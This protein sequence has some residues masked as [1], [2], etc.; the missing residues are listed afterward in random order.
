[1][2]R[3]RVAE[4]TRI[5]PFLHVHC[6]G[7]GQRVGDIDEHEQ[8]ETSQLGALRITMEIDR[9]PLSIARS[10]GSANP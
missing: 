1:M 6:Q 4:V 9:N 5:P 7:T 2:A 8:V 3:R 10:G